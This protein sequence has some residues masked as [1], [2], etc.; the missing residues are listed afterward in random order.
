M[1]HKT[2]HFIAL[3]AAALVASSAADAKTVSGLQ[4]GALAD[5]G[6]EPDETSLT[7]TGKMNAADFS[8]ILDNL[9]ALQTLDI[10]GATIAAYSGN[11][12]P[13]T[14]LSSSAEGM[15][16]D[17]GLTGLKALTRIILP[18]NL[19]AI[20]R[21]SLS[22]TGIT[23]L[24][25]PTG[26]KSIGAYAAMRCEKLQSINL[27]ASTTE[28]GT[29]AFAYCPKLSAVSI[30]SGVAAIPEGMFEACGSLKSIDLAA[31]ANCTEIGP[32]AFAMCNGAT[33]LTIPENT[34]AIGRGAMY[35]AGSIDVITLPSDVSY[36]DD[37]AMSA[38][39]GMSVLNVA[40]VENVPELGQN[41]WSRIEPSK[42]LLVVPDNSIADYRN[43]EQW[44][45][46]NIISHNDWQTSTD[47]IAASLADNKLTVVVD[48]D[49]MTVTSGDMTLGRVS[50]FD[51]AGHRIA[52]AEARENARF[53]TTSWTRG[54]YL[55]VAA[56]GARKVNI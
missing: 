47:N 54:I 17:Y 15:L 1:H 46:F 37:N 4:P 45:D 27:P 5:A 19:K 42:V 26:V 43:A 14:G 8:Y 18:T 21:G 55:V 20:G 41:V 56:G 33:E 50:V 29:R 49:I 39:S 10:S 11:A 24:N 51:M 32:W 3:A 6:I 12:L 16:P 53:D 44:K 40:A 35:G 7:I 25:I 31:M 34:E 23:T 9:N 48:G 28:I 36:I 38:M 2:N 52:T 22:G 13:Y 30:G